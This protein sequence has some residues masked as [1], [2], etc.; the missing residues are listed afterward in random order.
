M[1]VQEALPPAGVL[2]AEPLS[3]VPQHFSAN[4][5]SAVRGRWRPIRVFSTVCALRSLPPGE[6]AKCVSRQKSSPSGELQVA[7]TV[8]EQEALPPAGVLGAVP[9]SLKPQHFSR[10]PA[11][12]CFRAMADNQVFS[13]VCQAVPKAR[14]ACSPGGKE[15]K[16]S[17]AVQGSRTRRTRRRFRNENRRAAALRYLS[18]GRQS[19]SS[20]TGVSF[21]P[22]SVAAHMPL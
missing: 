14:F 8:E 11:K 16:E 6:Q 2:G 15:R 18:G 3:L 1:E 12:R 5:R 13:T 9:L 7:D 19:E 20:P 22:P 21:L 10:E 4:Q 17:L